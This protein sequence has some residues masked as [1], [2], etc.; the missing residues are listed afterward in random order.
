[1]GCPAKSGSFDT[2]W[3]KDPRP[4]PLLMKRMHVAEDLLDSARMQK[5]G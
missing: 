5:D 1:M 3:R 2:V 4:I